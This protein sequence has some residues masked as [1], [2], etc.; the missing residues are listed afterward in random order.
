M[1]IQWKGIIASLLGM[2]VFIGLF[3]SAIA[4]FS[5]KIKVE[6]PDVYIN[7]RL[8]AVNS[9]EEL[10][11]KI[12]ELLPNKLRLVVNGQ[13]GSEIVIPFQEIG[14][15]YLS[16]YQ[17]DYLKSFLDPSIIQKLYQTSMKKEKESI[18]IGID[19]LHYSSQ[20]IQD[21]VKENQ[22]RFNK[23]PKDATITVDNGSIKIISPEKGFNIIDIESISNAINLGLESRTF[24]GIAITG[25]EQEPIICADKLLPYTNIA[26]VKHYPIKMSADA[27][28][29]FATFINGTNNCFISKGQD[30]D[31]G[32][33]VQ[34]IYSVIITNP[35]AMEN[36]IK[37]EILNEAGLFIQTLYDAVQETSLRVEGYSNGKISIGDI[38]SELI[39]DVY[40]VV[41]N[42]EEKDFLIST[43]M[44]EK[45]VNIVILNK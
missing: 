12:E 21:W 37:E 10:H 6:K 29:A 17:M 2:C 43:Y 45:G 27:K 30:V 8:I 15:S 9:M 38:K 3:L 36:S 28:E 40:L 14:V 20:H 1:R 18:Y 5:F 23:Q 32:S 4:I 13:E 25:V 11:T 39:N 31:F 41:S 35:N 7:N 24:D 16:E 22:M 26:S 33:I 19:N 44:D 34:L 42:S